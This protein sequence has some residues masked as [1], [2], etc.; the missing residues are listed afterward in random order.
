LRTEPLGVRLAQLGSLA[1]SDHT[2]PVRGR[3]PRRDTSRLR[4]SSLAAVD[5]TGRPSNE[6]VGEIVGK[7]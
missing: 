3:R 1:D 2:R 5:S 7:L 4:R 6:G